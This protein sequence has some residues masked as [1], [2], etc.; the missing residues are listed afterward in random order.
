MK[1]KINPDWVSAPFEEVYFWDISK[2]HYIDPYPN[3]Y[4]TKSDA[5]KRKSPI[6]IFVI[7][8]DVN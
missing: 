8:Q 4:R 6:P 1:S 2:P 5:L 3:R 7:L